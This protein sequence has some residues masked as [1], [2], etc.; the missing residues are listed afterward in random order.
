MPMGKTSTLTF[1]IE[2]T[3]KEMLRSAAEREHRS[4]SNM[5]EVMI[6]NWCSQN[7]VEVPTRE[8]SSG[9]AG[10]PRSAGR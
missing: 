5:V 10:K 3:L 7:D 1:R 9:R 4:I 2:P 8:V 6:R